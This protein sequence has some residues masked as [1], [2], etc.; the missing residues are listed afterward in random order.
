[1][2]Q[3]NEADRIGV[4]QELAY[5]VAGTRDVVGR[6]LREF[7]QFTSADELMIDSRIYDPEARA[8]SFEILAEALLES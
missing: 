5:S 4:D 6:W 8:R 3:L 1:M 7:A 2:R